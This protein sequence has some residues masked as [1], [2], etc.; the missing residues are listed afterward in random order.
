MNKPDGK[1]VSKTFCKTLHRTFCALCAL[2]LA[3]LMLS[4]ALPTLA[5]AGETDSESVPL[6]GPDEAGEPEAESAALDDPEDVGNPDSEAHPLDLE[7]SGDDLEIETEEVRILKY[8]DNGDDVKALQTR[9]KELK[10]YTG[11][12]SGRFREGTRDAVLKFQKD[13]GIEATGV[14]DA[15][16]QSLIYS[17]RYRPLRY[18]AKGDD[19][20]ALQTRLMELGYYKAKVSGNYLE[21]TQSAVVTFQ[22]INALERT[23]IADPETQEVLFSASALD[24]SQEPK[25]KVTP[26]PAP[27]LA[28]YLV[29]D[30]RDNP[31]PMPEE[32]VAYTK[33]LKNGSSGKLVKQLQERMTVLGYYDGPISGNFMVKTTR[34]VKKIQSQNALEANGVVDETTWNLIFNDYTIVLPQDSPKPTPEPTPV[35]FAITV[36]VTNQVTTVYGLDENGEYTV[37]ARQMLCSTGMKATPS[38]PG[39]W[40][41]SGRKANWCTFPKWGNSYARYWTKINGSIA[42]HSVIYNAVDLKAVNTKSVNMLGSRASHGCIRLTVADAK[43]IYDNVGAGTVVSIVENLPS[44]PELVAALR[45]ELPVWDRKNK[46]FVYKD[47]PTPE[48]VFATD[49]K[50]DLEGKNLKEK[51]DNENVYWMQKKLKELGYYNDKCTGMMLGDTVKAVKAFQRDHGLYPSGSA[52][53]KL[54]DLMW[55]EGRA[56]ETEAPETE[57]PETEAPAPE[58]AVPPSTPTPPPAS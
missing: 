56:P 42:F 22:K 47:S 8:G 40:V 58:T 5:E 46:V 15:L 13:F 54:I 48:P 18:G 7:E 34:A 27:D 4:P 52:D 24:A 1:N 19:V 23:G 9:L 16:T 3:V 26:T 29:D 30:T 2:I 12:L 51:S 53:Q 50:P 11:N 28:H 36:D 55:E 6:D 14:A 20:K 41:L 10:Y 44:Q 17:T 49:Y 43:W 37:I 45:R 38:D 32:P 39:D 31:V 25:A 33:K 57:A 21:V 35:P